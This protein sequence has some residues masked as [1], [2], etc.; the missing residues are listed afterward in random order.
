MSDSI[1]QGIFDQVSLAFGQYN[2]LW[3]NDIGLS[4]DNASVKAQRLVH[5]F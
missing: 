2:I 4:L 1:A 5:P 3:E